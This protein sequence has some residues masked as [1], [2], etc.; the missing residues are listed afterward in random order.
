MAGVISEQGITGDSIPFLYVS[1]L[2][3]SVNQQRLATPSRYRSETGRP[4]A[5]EGRSASLGSELVISGGE[6]DS[7]DGFG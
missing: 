4:E 7:A 6:W 3:Q 2:T 5:G 1:D